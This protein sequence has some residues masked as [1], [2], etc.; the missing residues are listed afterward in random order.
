MTGLKRA[1]RR[2]VFS[3]AFPAIAAT[4]ATCV[5]PQRA[6]AQEQPDVLVTASREPQTLDQV[7]WSS[8]VLARPDIEASQTLSF[9][10]LLAELPGVQIDNTGGLGKQSS[11]FV[12]GMNADQTLVLINGVPVGSATTGL[13]PTELIPLDQIERV[14]VVRGPLSTLYGSDAM[15]AV[16]Q[17]FTRDGAQPGFGVDASTTGGTYSTFDEALSAHAG[18]GRVW[19][20]ASGQALHTSGFEACSAPAGSPPGDCFGGPPDH[21]GYLNRSGSFTAGVRVAPG[22][23]ASADSFLTSGHTDYDGTY[24][25]STEFLE[26]VTSA[27]LDGRI[28]DGWSVHATGGRDV[29]DAD[30]FLAAA[31]VDRFE[32]RRDTASLQIGGRMARALSLLAGS[33]W[34]GERIEA[35]DIFGNAISPIAFTRATRDSSG[36]FLELHGSTGPLTEL[37]GVRYEHDTQFGDHVTYDTGAGWRFGRHWRLTATWGTAFHAPTFNDLYYPSFPGFPPSSNP[38]LLPETSRSFELGIAADWGTGGWSLRA[39]QTDVSHLITY[40]PPNY[41][42][43]NLAEARI[44]GIE[45]RGVWRHNAWTLTGQATGLDPRDH[46]PPAVA[47]PGTAGNLLPRRARSSALLDLHRNLF[48]RVGISARGRWE[49]RRFDDLANTVPLGGYFLLDF[50][51]DAQLGHDWSVEAKVGNA[52]GRTYYTAAAIDSPPV[53]AYYNQPGRE[54]DLTL[55]YR[56]NS[57]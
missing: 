14:E 31:P 56:F 3:L 6:G 27:H 8:D 49:G 16:I 35:A 33:D 1:R 44:R 17:I 48:G 4:A 40:A 19:L 52:L 30:D 37:A 47:A 38:D 15:G 55:R 20:D 39:Y 50:L 21:D 43:Y 22:W 29:D 18:F 9:Q 24:S 2:A 25:D 54:L 11:L 36:T 13:P 46:S 45:L 34:Q 42:P 23:T 26:R 32:T 41:T 57:R 12:R 7:L 51:A 53:S 5:W 28:A 10:D